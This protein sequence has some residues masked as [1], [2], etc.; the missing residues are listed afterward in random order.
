MRVTT[1][2]EGQAFAGWDA[3]ANIATPLQLHSCQVREEWTDYNSHLSESYYLYVF[4]DSSDAFFRYFGIDEAYR[5]A[6]RSLFSVETHLRHLDEASLGDELDCALT[7]LGV[8]QRKLHIAHTMRRRRDGALVATAEQLLVHVDLQAG[9]AVA[10]APEI[11]ERLEAIARAHA[12]LDLPD[13]VGRHIA[14]QEAPW[15]SH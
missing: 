3:E 4:G 2:Y 7:L 11:L 10:F 5:A 15:T 14:F 13:W 12:V 6:G 1:P 8:T 9:R